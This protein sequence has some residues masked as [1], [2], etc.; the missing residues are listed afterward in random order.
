MLRCS[1]I[2]PFLPHRIRP[3]LPPLS[4]PPSSSPSALRRLG[5]VFAEC[6]LSFAECFEHSAY[7]GNPV[8]AAAAVRAQP[9]GAATSARRPRASSPMRSAIRGLTLV[10]MAIWLGRLLA[11][12]Y[13]SWIARAAVEGHSWAIAHRSWESSERIGDGRQRLH[14]HQFFFSSHHNKLCSQWAKQSWLVLGY[15]FFQCRLWVQFIMGN[16]LRVASSGWAG[17]SPT[18][19][20]WLITPRLAMCTPKKAIYLSYLSFFI[21]KIICS[22]WRLF[23]TP[24][25]P[26]YQ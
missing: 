10:S 5:K 16:G 14:L 3:S 23:S 11:Q 19:N 24:S 7:W 4:L 18:L 25:V 13:R 6:F 15:N 26:N 1:S 8:V 2:G 22:R 9:A 17:M 20:L 12:D 21:E